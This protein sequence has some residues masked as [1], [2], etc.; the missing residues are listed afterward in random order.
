M[1]LSTKMM[2]LEIKLGVCIVDKG[3]KKTET[4]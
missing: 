3:R 1:T 4:S 2:K